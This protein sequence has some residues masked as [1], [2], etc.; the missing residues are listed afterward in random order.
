M[1]VTDRENSEVIVR[2]S[3]SLLLQN[4]KLIENLLQYPYGCIEQTIASTLPNALAL[5]YAELF[6]TSV[7]RDTAKNNLQAWLDKIFRMQTYGWWKYWESD[8]QAHPYVTPYVIRSLYTFRSLGVEIPQSVIDTGLQNIIDMMTY[9]TQ[10]MTQD[11]DFRAEVFYTL[12]RARHEFALQVQKS[13]DQTKLS[14]HGKLAYIYGLY[15]LWKITDSD[16]RD[17][18]KSFETTPKDTDFW[19]WNADSDRAIFAQL[20]ID[21]WDL[22]WATLILDAILREKDLSSYYLSTQERIQLLLALLKHSEESKLESPLSMALRSGTM[23]ADLS[24]DPQSNGKTVQL[25]SK[26][27]GSS[28]EITRDRTDTTVYYEITQKNRPKNLTEL[29]PK[30]STGV[31]VERRFERVDISKWVDT[32]GKY[33]ATTPLISNTLKKGELYKVTLDVELTGYENKSWYYLTLEDFMPGA[34]RPIRGI[35]N[36]ESVFTRD[37]ADYSEDSWSY[38]EAKNDRILATSQYGYGNKR[39]YTYYIRPEYVWT[40]LLPPVTTYFMYRPEVFAYGKYEQI[41]V[42]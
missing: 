37:T 3:H 36:T 23:I 28:L 34:W 27:L 31:R 21:R 15:Y 29:E 25:S 4:E 14:R 11:P 9:E 16:I 12:A 39:T 26:K 6:W 32:H 18:K 22:A 2:V 41:T 33:I 7:D 17:M 35:F 42:E 38:V 13:I 19:Y 5:K 20:L 8:S 30:S 40:F 1:N 24:L 10:W